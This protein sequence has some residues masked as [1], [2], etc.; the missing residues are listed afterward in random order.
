MVDRKLLHE[1]VILQRGR[2]QR[3]RRWWHGAHPELGTII[4]GW[5]GRETVEEK[6]RILPSHVFRVSDN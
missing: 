1:E 2:L 3:V 4:Q 6:D 5:T